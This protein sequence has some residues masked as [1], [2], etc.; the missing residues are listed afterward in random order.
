[1]R[2]K[3]LGVV[4]EESGRGFSVVGTKLSKVITVQDN[5][6]LHDFL[7]HNAPFS[8][9]HFLFGLLHISF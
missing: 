2:V 1:M 4:I 3:K 5:C 7:L 6:L 9:S 8:Q